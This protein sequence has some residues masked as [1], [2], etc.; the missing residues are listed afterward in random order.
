[1]PFTLHVKKRGITVINESTFIMKILRIHLLIVFVCA[2]FNGSCGDS[3]TSSDQGQNAGV[4]VRTNSITSITSNSAQSGGNITADDGAGISARGVC[5]NTSESPTTS[6]NCTSDGSGT[7]SFTSNIT[8]LTAL[9]QY[10]VRAYAT[11][12]EGTT[13]G[14]Q[15]S[16]TT[17]SP[18]DT[19]TAIVEVTNP[20]TGRTWMDRNLGASRAATS[21]TDTEAYGDL[22]QWGR[23]ADG[24]EKRDSPTTNELSSTDNPGHGM[25]ILSTFE[26]NEDWRN[27]PNDELWQGADG[28]INNPCPSGFRLPTEEEWQAEQESWS[29]NDAAGA[30]ASPLKFPMA[31]YRLPG[32]QIVEVDVRGRYWTSTVPPSV[33]ARSFSFENSEASLNSSGR[34]YGLSVRCIKLSG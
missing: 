10:F 33:F 11:N 12:T 27:P 32:N 17:E 21:S 18:R 28:G 34:A 25:F 1:M 3:S 29:S 16:F 31:G 22:Y 4:T 26:Q 2:I 24:H 7:G 19:E 6:D 30:F 13:Y 14:N 9:T 8:N 5:W 23:A 20:A 15:V